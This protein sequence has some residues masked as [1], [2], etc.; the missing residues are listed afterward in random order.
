MESNNDR[1]KAARE[2][3]ADACGFAASKVV[4]TPAGNEWEVPFIYLLDDDQQVRWDNL[5]YEMQSWDR[6]DPI[7]LPENRLEDG[8]LIPSRVIK[9]DY[10]TP[11]QRDGVLIS[12][13][14][15]IRLAMALFGEE[16]YRKFKAE[17]G[18]S[19]DVALA[20]RQMMDEF[21]K[22]LDDDPKSVAGVD[23]LAVVPESD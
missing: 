6:E 7:V 19:S 13:P 22:R 9:G 18:R 15:N 10:V 8:T 17:G 1:V 5:Q 12:P 21:N 3:A 23:P 11:Y 20:V 4:L 16:G 2:Q 14:Y